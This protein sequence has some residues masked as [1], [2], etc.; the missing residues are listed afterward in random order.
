MKNFAGKL[1]WKV[2][3]HKSSGLYCYM[4]CTNLS[5]KYLE[6]ACHLHLPVHVIW[7][8]L[9]LFFF[10]KQN[11]SLRGEYIQVRTVIWDFDVVIT[12]LGRGS[13]KEF[14]LLTVPFF[15]SRMRRCNDWCLYFYLRCFMN[16]TGEITVFSSKWRV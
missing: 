15:W 10:Y 13:W 5:L 1:L 12:N 3:S 8:W 9:C 6:L 14:W 2:N 4:A 11:E 16:W 7:I